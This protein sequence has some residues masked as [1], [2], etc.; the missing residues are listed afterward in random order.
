MRRRRWHATASTGRSCRTSSIPPGTAVTQLAPVLRRTTTGAFETP[1]DERGIRTFEATSAFFRPQAYESRPDLRPIDAS[2]ARMEPFA[3]YVGLCPSSPAY[4]AERAA[5]MEEVASTLQPD[6][7]FVSFIRYPRLLG[8]VDAGDDA[9]ARSS[10]YCFCD[11]CLDR[12]QCGDRDRPCRTGPCLNKRRVLQHELRDRMDSLEVPAHR[13]R[14]RHAGGSGRA[15][16]TRRRAD[17]QRAGVA[18][19][20]DYDDAVEEVLGQ[21]LEASRSRPTTS[22]SCST[23]RSCDGN[24]PSGQVHGAR[25]TRPDRADAARL[26]PDEGRLPGADSTRADAPP[27][28]RRR[29]SSFGRSSRSAIQRPMGSWSTTGA[30]SWRT[31]LTGDGH[32][33]AGFRAFK[34]GT[35]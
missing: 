26:P 8:A 20:S 1:C 29:R 24:P 33:T 22:S 9:I 32:L 2:G 25:S 4:L 23:T 35:L 21:G 19:E 30:T 3:W 17:D 34:D 14:G 15:W 7:V 27:G 12:F 11:R 31:K 16:P 10:E 5:V 18:V 6:G 13:R 28:D